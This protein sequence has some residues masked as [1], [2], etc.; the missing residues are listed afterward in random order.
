S[1]RTGSAGRCRPWASPGTRCSPPGWPGRRSAGWPTG[2]PARPSTG[3]RCG[4]GRSLRP[5]PAAG[6][7]PGRA[8]GSR[9]P[10]P[11]ARRSTWPGPR[12]GGLN[13][14][15]DSGDGGDTYAWC[16]PATDTV[17]D[18]PTT[19]TV[20]VEE[21]GPLRGRLVITA[22]YQWPASADGDEHACTR[23]SATTATATIR[24]AVSL[25][26][27]DPVVA[28][29]PVLDNRCRD[30]RLRAHF[31]LPVPVTGSDAGCAFAV[32]HRGLVAE[33]GPN[34]SPPPTF[35]ARRFVDCSRT[36]GLA[37]IAGGSFDW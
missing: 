11:T 17:I 10:G 35:P 18:R 34:E 32:V 6:P 27:G 21:T 28:V 37:V 36:V 2:S 8:C 7:T 22:T 20:D 16:P 30:H 25:V 14:Y 23:R 12:A 19:V 26:A 1:A 9:R 31:P 3:T 24:T 4:P 29:E 15:A 13:R 5:R 33:G